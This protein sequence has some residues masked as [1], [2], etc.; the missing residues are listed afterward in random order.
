MFG[1]EEFGHQRVSLI[2]RNW[3]DGDTCLWCLLW[4][5]LISPHVKQQQQQQWYESL[6][7]KT[8]KLNNCV[9][10]EP[11]SKKISRMIG[12]TFPLGLFFK[13][14]FTFKILCI[15]IVF[16]K[17]IMLFF[18]RNIL[19][20][21]SLLELSFY[22]FMYSFIICFIYLL[23]YLLSSHP[24]FSWFVFTVCWNMFFNA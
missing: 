8:G 12:L 24:I 14:F 11:A 21:Y 7:G 10:V 17:N 5:F 1:W 6:C 18:I 16:I 2:R 23:L 13:L 19:N 22:L 9:V 3:T 15:I 20:M 4:F